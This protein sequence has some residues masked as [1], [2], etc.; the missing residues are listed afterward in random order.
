MRAHRR[1]Y[2]PLLV[3]IE[4]QPSLFNP[5]SECQGCLAK[6]EDRHSSCREER[7]EGFVQRRS[8]HWFLP[9]RS[10]HPRILCTA[11]Q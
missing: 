8:N 2:L 4:D 1:T 3:F 9:G 7:A 5:F 11:L 10:A 6:N